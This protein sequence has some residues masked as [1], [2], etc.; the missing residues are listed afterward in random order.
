MR[1]LVNV[2]LGRDGGDAL[3]EKERFTEMRRILTHYADIEDDETTD[4]PHI[5]AC[6]FAGLYLPKHRQ[7]RILQNDSRRSNFF[8][9]TAQSYTI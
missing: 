9:I 6:K 8:S 3:T 5:D 1:Q 2:L 7:T 4:G